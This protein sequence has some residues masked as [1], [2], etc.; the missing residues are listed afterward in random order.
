MKK[1]TKVLILT[2]HES[3]ML[4]RGISLFLFTT[5]GVNFQV[6]I[7]PQ[8]ETRPELAITFGLT[9]PKRALTVVIRCIYFYREKSQDFRMVA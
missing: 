3:L 4:P 9:R 6:E 2:F 5:F 1:F 7:S 8:N